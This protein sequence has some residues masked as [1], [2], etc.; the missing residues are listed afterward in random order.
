LSSLQARNDPLALERHPRSRA[1]CTCHRNDQH[2]RRDGSVRRPHL[3][4]DRELARDH[5]DGGACKLAVL[6]LCREASDGCFAIRIANGTTLFGP[7][8][9]HGK[10][11]DAPV[12]PWTEHHS[13]ESVQDRG[14]ESTRGFEESRQHLLVG[15]RS[16]AD[17][18]DYKAEPACGG[19]RT[20]A[21]HH[22][23]SFSARRAMDT[24]RSSPS[25]SIRRTP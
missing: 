17:T 7:A 19:Q 2:A 13:R 25:I 16:A 1:D 23:S 6:N 8:I 22:S 15:C 4:L 24:A 12:R 9:G 14:V 5:L 3:G 10:P 11:L 21:R 20:Q 18:A